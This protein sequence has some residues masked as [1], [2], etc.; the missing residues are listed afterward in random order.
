MSVFNPTK[1]KLDI[2]EMDEIVRSTEIMKTCRALTLGGVS[3]MNS[4]LDYYKLLAGTRSI[5]ALGIFANYGSI[6]VGWA[7][8]TYED[9]Q[10]YFTA[11]DGNVCTQIY[12]HPNYRRQ[13]IGK[14]LMDK[15]TILAKPDTMNVYA[16][17][18]WNFFY[19]FIQKHSHI[20]ELMDD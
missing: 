7:L 16:W 14:K 8:F 10:F 20:K 11:R 1:I 5:N 4:A 15:A 3:G 2:I 13:G 6:C 9:D 17:S 12:V 18:N 19:P